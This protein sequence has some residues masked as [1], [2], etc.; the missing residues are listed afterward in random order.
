MSAKFNWRTHLNVHPAAELLP[1]FSKAELKELADDIAANGL[2]S[3]IVLWEENDALLDGRH[4]LDA[5]ALLGFLCVDDHDR[6]AL[7]RL[8]TG[9]WVADDPRM[10]RF[11][12]VAGDP[13]KL[14]LSYNLH[15][16]HLTPDQ[17][18]DLIAKV[19][20]AKPEQSNR[21]I[22]KQV[23]ADDKTVA[24]VRRAMESTAEIP[25]SEKTVGADGKARQSKPAP[26]ATVSARDI[27][28]EQFDAHVLELV[29][30]TCGKKPERFAKTGVAQRLHDLIVHLTLI[31][32]TTIK[33][34][35]ADGLENDPAISA[36]KRKTEY[37]TS[38][39]GSS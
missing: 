5:L 31:H 13:Y 26:R 10:L 14:A 8:W 21:A 25:Q 4:R 30:I 39:R 36:E 24:S 33:S 32:Q 29:R 9:S 15:R 2:R 34:Y 37:A 6:L 7:N 3:S 1:S 35:A 23:K 27:C 22:A 20:K 16:R 12:R 38:E 19:L 11:V 18:R 28:L 17:K